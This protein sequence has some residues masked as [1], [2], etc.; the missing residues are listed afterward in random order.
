MPE[1]ALQ[2]K[3]PCQGSETRRRHRARK[4][5]WGKNGAAG[6]ILVACTRRG[7]GHVLSPPSSVRVP[8]ERTIL[9]IRIKTSAVEWRLG[10]DQLPP[11]RT[12]N[13]PHACTGTSKCNQLKHATNHSQLFCN[14]ANA[15]EPAGPSSKQLKCILAHRR[16]R[17]G[18]RY[19]HPAS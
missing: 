18:T 1:R 3:A 2:P 19:T 5:E 13:N 4:T 15:S 7:V 11:R 8:L 10:R 9:T 17:R 16:E 14:G 6:S 12:R